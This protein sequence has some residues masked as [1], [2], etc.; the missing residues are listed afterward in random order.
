MSTLPDNG[1]AQ[2]DNFGYMT[3]H[4]PNAFEGLPI[5]G[6]PVT[7]WFPCFKCKGHGKW[8]LTLF[9]TLLH[10]CDSCLGYGWTFR[11]ETHEHVWS[12]EEIERSLRRDTCT[13]CGKVSIT[14]SSD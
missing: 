1:P 7:G 6:S 10:E 5:L 13:L 14:D 9:P 4:H 11:N 12:T 3:V 8:N 2:Y